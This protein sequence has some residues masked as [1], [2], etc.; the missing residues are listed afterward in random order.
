MLVPAITMQG[1]TKLQPYIV[2]I[3]VYQL[4]LELIGRQMARECH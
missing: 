2:F 1:I 3:W 4:A